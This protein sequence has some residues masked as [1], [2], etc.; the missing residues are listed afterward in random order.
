LL[1]KYTDLQTKFNVN[2]VVLTEGGL[3]PKLLNIKD[4]LIE[5]INFRREVVLRRSKYQLQ[6]NKERL[7]ILQ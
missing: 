7:H 4:L 5:F 1:Y 3:Q 2:N 6:K